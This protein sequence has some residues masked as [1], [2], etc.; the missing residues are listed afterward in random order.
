MR[1]GAQS[2]YKTLKKILLH[3]PGREVGLV[4]PENTKEFLFR[5]PVNLKKFRKQHDELRELLL[6]EGIEILLL[7]ELLE[8]DQIKKILERSPNSI[9]VRDL[10]SITKGGAIVMKMAKKAR[11]KEPELFKRV[12]KRL[13]IPI[14]ELSEK[15]RLEGGDFVYLSEDEL[16]IG[17]G[18]RSN[19]EGIREVKRLI[20]SRSLKSLLAVPLPKERV[21]L[22]GCLMIPSSRIALMH[23]K[24]VDFKPSLL[25]RDEDYE[26]VLLKDY[27]EEMD[28]DLIQITDEEVLNF[29][30]NVVGLG[31][32]KILAYTG[33]SRIRRE[34]EERGL[35]VLEF[36]GDELK[37]GGG[38]P[39]CMT[40]P[41][42]R[43]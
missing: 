8:G 20:L 3:R 29:G 35:E 38:G 31:G 39:H 1:F 37:K 42:L 5:E 15:A 19:L 17:F 40:C 32:N 33:N 30:C 22:D 23:E 41:I 4:T 2:E 12:M 27:L 11:F 24:S 16:M 21:H 26:S 36:L 25:F 34:L 43:G 14:S 9:Y 18:P 7:R 28:F 10:C 13:R 6:D